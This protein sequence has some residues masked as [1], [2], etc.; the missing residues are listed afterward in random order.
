[1]L[2]IE[3]YYSQKTSCNKHKRFSQNDHIPSQFSIGMKDDAYNMVLC[4][5]TWDIGQ[6]SVSSIV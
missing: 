5:N 4:Y 1:M 6:L 3:Y 2:L